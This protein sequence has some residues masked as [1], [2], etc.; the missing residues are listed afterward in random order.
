MSPAPTRIALMATTTGSVVSRR[1]PGSL[2]F[3]GVA[4]SEWNDVIEFFA[5]REDAETFLAE[6][7]ADE[8][9]W[10]DM[11]SEF[12]FEFEARARTKSASA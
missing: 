5:R 3:Y 6:C 11:M 9:D 2:I 1:D 4:T 10:R 12:E 7:L 8:P